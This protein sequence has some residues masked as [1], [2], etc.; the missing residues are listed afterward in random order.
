VPS[1]SHASIMKLVA[2]DLIVA[3]S[4][5]REVLVLAALAAVPWKYPV[6]LVPC[7]ALALVQ[8]N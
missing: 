4:L 8:L 1:L 7:C 3:A 6:Q 5:E 2:N